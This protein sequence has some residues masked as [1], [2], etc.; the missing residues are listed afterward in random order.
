MNIL[1]YLVLLLIVTGCNR[2]NSP[3]CQLSEVK[4]FRFFRDFFSI[5][6]PKDFKT[7]DSTNYDF[8]KNDKHLYNAQLFTDD[9]LSSVFITVE[10][11]QDYKINRNDVSENIRRIKTV[12]MSMLE[13]SESDQLVE[14]YDTTNGRLY[15]EFL[16]D[17]KRNGVDLSVGGVTFYHKKMRVE[18]Q[19]ILNKNRFSNPR[20]AAECLISSLITK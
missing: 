1:Y 9:S 17:G 3:N 7:I 8:E 4:E 16:V 11:F 14:R 20:S 15:G 6:I 13:G 2:D 18:I 10:N 12:Q 5:N 19:V